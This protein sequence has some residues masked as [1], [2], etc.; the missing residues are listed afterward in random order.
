[1]NTA[2]R[3]LAVTAA[4][5]LGGNLGD[6][7][8]TLHEALQALDALPQTRLLRASRLYRTPAWGRTEQPD[9]INGAALLQTRLDARDLLDALLGI[10]RRFGRDREQGERWGPRTLDLDLLL[11]GDAAIDEPGL[12]VPHQHL[13]ERAFALLPL[14]E[15][16]PDLPVPGRGPVAGLLAVV[17]VDGCMPLAGDGG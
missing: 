12:R 15:I 6:V 1:V 17:D 7:A 3:D 14:A 5:G 13:H 11:Y 16:A 4:I 2:L 10:E 9:F 8:T